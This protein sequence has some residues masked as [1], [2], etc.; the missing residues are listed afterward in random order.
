MKTLFY[1]GILFLLIFE[2]ANVYFIMPMPGS[3]EMNSIDIAYFLHSWR[4]LFRVLFTTL[5]IYGIFSAFSVKHWI[6]IFPLLALAISGYLIY[7]ANFK[8][9]ADSMFLQP[10]QL[11]MKSGAENSVAPEKLVLGITHNG[12]AKAYPIQYM[13]Y[14]HQVRDI[15]G[16]KPV[17]VTYCTVCRTGRVFEPVVNGKVENFRLVGMDHYNAMFEDAT[18]KSWWRQATGES[19]A[20]ELAGKE[21]KTFSSLQTTLAKWTELHPN[22]LVMQADSK[23]QEAY[24][25]MKIY[26]KG[27]NKGRLTRYDPNS[28]KDKSWIVG[29]AIG[30]EAKAYDWNEL[31]KD[32]IIYDEL[33]GTPIAIVLAKDGFSFITLKRTS[34]DQKFTIENDKIITDGKIYNFTGKAQSPETKDLAIID[35]HQ[36]YWHS[37]KTFHPQT[38]SFHYN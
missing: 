25:G 21:L 4:W 16:G 37:W 2:I 11:I 33:A 23:F 13:G 29:V 35:S 19:I 8:M 6:K 17:M 14:H 28:W 9:A 36:E 7:T 5:I 10:S 26:E 18:T 38:K 27:H 31:T 34:K 32:R 3:Q 15:V 20:G 12:E 30:T 22:T 1:F 24:E